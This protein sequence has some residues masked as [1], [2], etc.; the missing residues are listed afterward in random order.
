MSDMGRREFIT[1]LGERGRAWACRSAVTKRALALL[2]Q[3][4]KAEGHEQR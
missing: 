4:T 3:D 1:L 2:K